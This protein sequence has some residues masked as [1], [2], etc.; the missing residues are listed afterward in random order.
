MS[1]AVPGWSRCTQLSY[2]PRAYALLR[3]EAVTP[4]APLQGAAA[5]EEALQAY[6]TAHAGTIVRELEDEVLADERKP[7]S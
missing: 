3:V 2:V 1:S 7:P 6:L 4:A 5:R